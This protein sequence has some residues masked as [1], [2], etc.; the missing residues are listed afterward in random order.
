MK[1]EDAVKY[2]IVVPF[3]NERDSIRPLY[4]K[5][6]ETMVTLGSSF[7][8][9]FVDDGSQDLSYKTLVEMCQNDP[10]LIFVRLRRNFGQT[11]ALQAGF[12]FASG[13]I[14]IAMDGDLQHDPAEIPNFVA[15]MEEGYD[16]VSGWRLQRADNWLT[17]RLSSLIANWLMSKVCHVKVHD[18]GQPSRPIDVRSSKRSSSTASCTVLFPLWPVAA[19]LKRSP[20]FLLRIPLAR[21]A[22]QIMAF[23]GRSGFCWTSSTSSSSLTTRPG[24]CSSLGES[25]CWQAALEQLLPC[26]SLVKF[27]LGRAIMLQH[28]PLLFRRPR[29]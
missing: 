24:H 8:M 19:E 2:S 12:D 15:K 14:I 11:A 21:M 10:R 22:N 4:S 23:P 16:I 6:I 28:G 20:K 3:Y 9:I 18:S 25:D 26:S 7:E 5:I 27:G 17:R 13:E 1:H 29:P